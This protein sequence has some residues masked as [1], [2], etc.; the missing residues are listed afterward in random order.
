MRTLAEHRAAVLAL[1][2]PLPEHERARRVRAGARA[3]RATSSPPTDLPG[4]D[5]SAMDGYAVRAAEL[6]GATLA[7]PRRA[8]RSPTTSPRVTPDGTCCDPARCCGS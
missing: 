5:N 7:T 6:A 2:S 4:F 3:R 1:V 8:A